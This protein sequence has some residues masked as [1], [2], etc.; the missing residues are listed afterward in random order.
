MTRLRGFGMIELLI[1]LV[2][3]AALATVMLPLQP[4]R[5]PPAQEAYPQRARETEQ[6]LQQ[7]AEAMRQKICVEST[8]TACPAP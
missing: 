2:A 1:I 5:E 6:Q 4:R 8:G 7:A 3:I